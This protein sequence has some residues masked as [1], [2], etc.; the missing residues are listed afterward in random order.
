MCVCACAMRAK[1]VGRLRMRV[2]RCGSR[3]ASLSF[4]SE[5]AMRSGSISLEPV[6]RMQSLHRIRYAVGIDMLAERLSNPVCGAI[7]SLFHL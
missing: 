7:E 6:P 3:D 1:S 2:S 5:F 4:V